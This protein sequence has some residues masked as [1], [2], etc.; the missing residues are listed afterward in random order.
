LDGIDPLL[1]DGVHPSV[2]EHLIRL[3]LAAI[4]IAVVVRVFFWRKSDFCIEVKRGKV[5]YR[6]SIPFSIQPE[7]SDFL[8]HDLAIQGPARVY[9]IRMKSG[10]RTW[11][12]GRI[13]DGEKQRIRNFIITRLG[14]R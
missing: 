1:P 14:S 5:T 10:W 4:A 2:W 6:G 12:R 3:G 13:G 11:F 9:A 7:C 8:L